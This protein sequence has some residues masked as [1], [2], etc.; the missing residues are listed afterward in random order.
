M[1]YGGIADGGE[2][3]SEE[4]DVI[5]GG[6]IMENEAPQMETVSVEKVG[7]T[8][9]SSGDE[10][11][12]QLSMSRIMPG[13]NIA[14]SE[15]YPMFQEEMAQPQTSTLHG[16]SSNQPTAVQSQVTS[17][18][19]RASS[20]LQPDEAIRT[21]VNQ[22]K[23]PATDIKKFSGDPLQYTRFMR[24]FNSR[25]VAYTST[26]EERMNYLE[27]FT[28]EEAHRIVTGFSCLDPDV[29]YPAALKEMQDRY[30]DQEK[31]ANAYVRRALDWPL[32]AKDNPKALD[33][34]G[35]FLVECEN[36]VNGIDAIKILEYPDNLTKLVKKLPYHL[37]DRWRNVYQRLKESKKSV[38]FGDLTTFVKKE[39]KKIIDPL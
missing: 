11:S 34:F 2:K 28:T 9:P 17:P 36:A 30:G 35:I 12:P 20:V 33:E 19:R 6:G 25:V 13:T 3:P 22:M 27:Q 32:I 29:G 31:I 14:A 39:A 5:I 38:K 26:S 18:S 10:R 4:Y 7:P 23:K 21:M 16:S 24:Q 15:F 1:E 8:S 37:H